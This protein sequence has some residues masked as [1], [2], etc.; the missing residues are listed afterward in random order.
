MPVD[1]WIE[2]QHEYW[3]TFDVDADGV[4]LT[5]GS[6]LDGDGG[7]IKV[8]PDGSLLVLSVDDDANVRAWNVEAPHALQLAEAIRVRVR[9]RSLELGTTERAEPHDLDDRSE[10][11][12]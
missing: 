8:R 5:F 6:E 9:A 10:R 7:S 12:R 3:T 2:S 4:I 1:E 11:R